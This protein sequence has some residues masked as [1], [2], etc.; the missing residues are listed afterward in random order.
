MKQEIRPYLPVL[1]IPL[2]ILSVFPHELGHIIIMEIL[3]LEWVFVA[4]PEKFAIQPIINSDRAFEYYYGNMTLHCMFGGIFAFLVLL[5]LGKI[6]LSF[7]IVPYYQLSAGLIE[8]MMNKLRGVGLLTVFD[9]WTIIILQLIVAFGLTISTI[10]L[11]E[12][13]SKNGGHTD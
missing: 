1:V 6:D 7:L 4:T 10:Y 13:L 9:L 8:P 11:R 12:V 2:L 3:G 5:P